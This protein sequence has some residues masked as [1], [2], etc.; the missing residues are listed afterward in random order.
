M[1]DGGVVDSIPIRFSE[2]IGCDKNI[3]I[4]TQ[5]KGFVKKQGK[6]LFFMKLTMKQKYPRLVRAMARRPEVYNQTL[7]YI[8][9]RE[10]INAAF[11]IRPPRKLEIGRIEKDPQKLRQVYNLG[12]NEA[13]RLLP[14][15]RRFLG[16]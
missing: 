16:Q 2:S 14:E 15:I 12:R 4:L 5:P 11:V 8:E 1:L 6:S 10:R 7:R 3:V 13:K 9:E